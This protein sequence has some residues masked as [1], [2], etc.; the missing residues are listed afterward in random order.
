MKW[1]AELLAGLIALA[2]C[3][4]VSGGGSGVFFSVQD[5]PCDVVVQRVAKA[6]TKIQAELKPTSE[7][8]GARGRSWRLTGGDDQGQWEVSVVVE[9]MPRGGSRIS[10]ITSQEG[11]QAAKAVRSISAVVEGAFEGGGK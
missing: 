10:V 6:L 3:C 4:A 8:S 5:M 9:C 7:V 2:G 11:P 1:L